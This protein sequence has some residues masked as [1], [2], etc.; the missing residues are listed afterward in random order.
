[1]PLD[2][3]VV[4]LLAIMFFGGL[5]YIIWKGRKQEKVEGAAPPT[6]IPDT[7]QDSAENT[8]REKR[9]KGSRK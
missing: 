8:P 6:T 9:R 1:M 7:V 2:K 3:I 5:A 4:I